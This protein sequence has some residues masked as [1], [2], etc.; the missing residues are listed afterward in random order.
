MRSRTVWQRH[1]TDLDGFELVGVQDPAPEALA[2]A[3]EGGTV[4]EGQTFADLGE[5][6]E[7]TKPDALI[8]CPI[9]AAHATAVE[10]GLAAGCHVLVEK[11]F[12]DD[13]ASAVRLTEQAKQ[14]GR[15]LA[16]VQNWRTKSVGAALKRA[17]DEGAIGTPGQVFFRYL[18][19]R[20]AP[21]LPDYLFEEADPVLWGMSIH[22]F[23]LF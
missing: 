2:K 4:G 11:P 10:T 1:L 18:R 23:D 21:H 16:V 19:D 15:V 7:G 5:M 14:Q 13:L 3:V 9:I 8:A 20:E 12:T 22:H 6:L 17:I